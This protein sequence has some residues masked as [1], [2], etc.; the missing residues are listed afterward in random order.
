MEVSKYFEEN[1]TACI[2]WA[3]DCLDGD[4]KQDAEDIVSDSLIEILGAD[5]RLQPE[6]ATTY[7]F[8]V[9]RN[10]CLDHMK[11]IKRQ[12]EIE[13]ENSDEIIAALYGPD[14]AAA[15]PMEILMAEEEFAD[16]IEGLS[17]TLKRVLQRIYL[18]GL[19]PEELAEEEGVARNAIDQRV[20]NLKKALKGEVNE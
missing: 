19:T 8:G 7:V 14:D 3:T 11:T 4:F 12:K 13:A 6:T 20:H 5:T 2:A 9:I 18:D 10:N 1:Y 16:R 15:D 17:D